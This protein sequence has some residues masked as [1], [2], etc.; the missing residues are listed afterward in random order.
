MP[1]AKKQPRAEQLPLFVSADHPEPDRKPVLEE[2][3]RLEALWWSTHPTNNQAK[4][5]QGPFPDGRG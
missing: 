2:R 3:R 1:R 5:E 4:G